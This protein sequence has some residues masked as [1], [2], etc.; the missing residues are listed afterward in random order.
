MEESEKPFEEPSQQ[1]PTED[2]DTME[3]ST[4]ILIMMFIML[5]SI[6]GGHYIKKKQFRWI[7]EA[8]LTTILG[9]LAGLILQILDVEIMT[10]LNHHFVRLFMLVLLPPIIFESGFNM[11]KRQFFKNI[12]TILMFAFFGTFIAIL[13][14]SILF[15]LLGKSDIMDGS[16]TGTEAFAFGSLISATDPVSVLAIF[17]LLNADANLYT[18]VFG[19]SIFNDAIGI[20]MYRTVVEVD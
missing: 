3:I 16:F 13:S 7:Q 9:V 17:K 10:N 12:G 8:E 20:V 15:Y 19:E 1:S 2:E 4:E 11:H 14:T 18:I 6:M 5:I